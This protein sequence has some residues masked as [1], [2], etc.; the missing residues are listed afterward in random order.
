[1][2]MNSPALNSLSDVQ[3]FKHPSLSGSPGGCPCSNLR[4]GFISSPLGAFPRGGSRRLR[5]RLF[6]AV[7]AADLSANF[8]SPAMNLSETDQELNVQPAAS[9]IDQSINYLIVGLIVLGFFLVT[10]M[11]LSHVER[12]SKPASQTTVEGEQTQPQTEIVGAGTP[13]TE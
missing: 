8:L 3:C 5:T 1:M 12:L 10:V 2:P 7:F 11:G 4:L 6:G 9:G 13:V